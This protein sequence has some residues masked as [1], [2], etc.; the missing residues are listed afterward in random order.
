MC[1]CG[2][3]IGAGVGCV[4]VQG[5]GAR[6]RCGSVRFKCLYGAV[7]ASGGRLGRCKD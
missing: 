5:L 1:W 6:T 2:V 7:M 3:W 4:N